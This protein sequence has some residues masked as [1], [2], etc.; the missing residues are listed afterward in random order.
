[1]EF[2]WIS[3]MVYEPDDTRHFHIVPIGDLRDHEADPACW[4][5]P[6]EDPDDLGIWVHNAMDRREE[7]ERGR[8]KH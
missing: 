5:S 1:M 2:N 8:M 6:T 3:A 7:Y 4:C